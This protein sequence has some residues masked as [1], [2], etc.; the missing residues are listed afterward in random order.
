MPTTFRSL[1]F[2]SQAAYGLSMPPLI[3]TNT[4]SIPEYNIILGGGDD[5]IMSASLP[6]PQSG[7]ANLCLAP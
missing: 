3:A 5:Q 2:S 1:P 4:V 6:A 7:E